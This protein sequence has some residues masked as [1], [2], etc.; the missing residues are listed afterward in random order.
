VALSGAVAAVECRTLDRDT[1]LKL[2]QIQVIGTHNSYHA[3]I[4][5]SEQK[6]WEIKD[7]DVFRGLDYRHE[8][9][10]RQLDGGVRQFELDIFADSQGGRFVHPAGPSMV[11]EAQLSSAVRP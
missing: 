10:T 9:L 3:G 4:A 5:P 8:T 2:N 11:A 6:L 1:A 7:P